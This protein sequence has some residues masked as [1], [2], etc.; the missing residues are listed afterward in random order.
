MCCNTII[1]LRGLRRRGLG[2]PR[3]AGGGAA[4]DLARVRYNDSNNMIDNYDV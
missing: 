3:D 2:H 1:I 4:R